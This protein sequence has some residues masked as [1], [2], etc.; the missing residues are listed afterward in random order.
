MV[1]LSNGTATF[2]TS[3]LAVGT[4]SIRAVYSGDSD[5][6]SSQS[7]TQNYKVR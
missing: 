7:S 2:S 3:S 1:T 4:H 5:Y 6:N